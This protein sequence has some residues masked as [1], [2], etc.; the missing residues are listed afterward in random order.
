MD[1]VTFTINGVKITNLLSYRVEAN[2]YTADHAFSLELS[3]P[4]TN[5][6]K[7]AQC[8]LMVNNE[9][10]LTGITDKVTRSYDKS[11]V[12]LQVEGRDLM[13][14][15]VDSCCATF[16]TLKGKTLP[17]LAETL[18]ANTPFINRSQIVY[19]EGLLAS[20]QT[21]GQAQQSSATLSSWDTPQAYA[22]VE[23]GQTIF[24]VLSN[25]AKSRGFMFF[26]L[27]NGTFV[28][29]RPKSQGAAA[30]NL[31]CKKPGP[32]NSVISG[33]E[34]HDCSRGFSQVT[35]MGQQQGQNSIAAAAI[36]TT[37]TVTD[38]SFPFYKPY[39]TTN[40]NDQQ[41]PALHARAIME[42]MKHDG[43]SLTYKASRLTQNGKAWTVN[44]L[45]HV[46]D[47]VLGIDATYLIFGRVFEMSRNG[48]YTTL[49]L[50]PPGLVA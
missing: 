49:R 42:K 13:G 17:N 3:H 20:K 32:N 36:N 47:D 14:L 28:F 33:E 11:G 22:Q 29:G 50:G 24:D 23:P 27:P 9:L 5:I 7:G 34:C 1:S 2:L 40:N 48:V 25:F 15:L 6:A 38:A 35:V 37:A 19:Q 41:S 45:C 16:P 43:Y 46:T 44:E 4:E 31:V 12:R 8:K 18:L 30:F 21:G 26:S 39:V 10:V